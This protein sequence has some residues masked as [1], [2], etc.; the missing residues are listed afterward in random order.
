MVITGGCVVG[1]A[2]EGGDVDGRVVRVVVGLIVTG[3]TGG[4][5]LWMFVGLGVA[6]IGV[7]VVGRVVW[8]GD[9]AVVTGPM[10]TMLEKLVK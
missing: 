8:G 1:G 3:A 6:M 7:R 4:L 10:V 5:V 9:V 2:V